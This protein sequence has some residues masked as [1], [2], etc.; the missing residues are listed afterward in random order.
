M[1]RGLKIYKIDFLYVKDIKIFAKNESEMNILIQR[2]RTYSQDI[3]LEFFCK[4]HDDDDEKWEKRNN[5]RNRTSKS[6]KYQN[7]W[8]EKKKYLEIL[9]ADTIKQVEMTE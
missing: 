8:I 4:C 9:E 1:N 7:A 6:E 2:S 5:R 3:K